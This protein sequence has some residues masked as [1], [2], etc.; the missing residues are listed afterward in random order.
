MSEEEQLRTLDLYMSSRFS[1]PFWGVHARVGSEPLMTLCGMIFDDKGKSTR[2]GS[3]SG[4]E[5]ITPA[6]SEPLSCPQCLEIIEDLKKMETDPVRAA[7]IDTAYQGTS[8][9]SGKEVNGTSADLSPKIRKS[10][11]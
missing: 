8:L 9:I 3:Y 1:T 10:R 11:L 6:D 5:V 7:Q 2:P 4:N